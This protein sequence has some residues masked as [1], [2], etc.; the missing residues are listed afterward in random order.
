MF[1]MESYFIGN[2]F[3]GG[4]GLNKQLACLSMRL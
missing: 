3:N 1:V 2:L 4:V